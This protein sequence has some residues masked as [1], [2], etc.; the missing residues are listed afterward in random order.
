[1]QA[2]GFELVKAGYSDL[3][4]EAWSCAVKSGEDEAFVISLL[5]QHLGSSRD[6][7]NQL[8]VTVVRIGVPDITLDEGSAQ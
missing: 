4:G 5:P 3:A 2:D 6:S 8:T 1:L 7:N